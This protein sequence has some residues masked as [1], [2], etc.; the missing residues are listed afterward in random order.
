MT[1]EFGKET[2]AAQI[3]ALMAHKKRKRDETAE[4]FVQDMRNQGQQANVGVQDT[5]NYIIEGVFD[6]LQAKMSPLGCTNFKDLKERR[7]GCERT[8]RMKKNFKGK[9]DQNKERKGETKE[10]NHCWN[11]GSKDHIRTKCPDQA[12][13]KKC[14]KCQEFGHISTE[15]TQEEKSKDKKNQDKK[16]ED[17]KKKYSN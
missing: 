14:F 1:E 12:K 9:E 7:E 15:C 8:L 6:D 11:C 13:G 17:K 4:H 16:F 5:I 10:K 3:Y 2:S